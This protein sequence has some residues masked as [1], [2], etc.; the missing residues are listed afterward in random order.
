MLL[1]FAVIKSSHIAFRI[2][3]KEMHAVLLG[4]PEQRKIFIDLWKSYLRSQKFHLDME[5]MDL[6]PL[7]DHIGDGIFTK[8][9]IQNDHKKAIE[10][11]TVVENELAADPINW[12]RV[13]TAWSNWKYDHLEHLIKEEK[14][15][16]PLSIRIA[17]GHKARCLVI[18][19]KLITPADNRDS[20]EFIQFLAWC[21]RLLSFY[22]T[23]SHLPSVAT[24]IFVRGLHCCSDRAQWSRFVP[25]LKNACDQSIWAELVSKYNI[26]V[27]EEDLHSNSSLSP[28]LPVSSTVSPPTTTAV[29][30]KSSSTSDTI[31]GSFFHF[32][33]VEFFNSFCTDM[34]YFF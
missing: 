3:I 11:E 23:E 4:P 28:K 22:T 15:W 21:V 10:L 18:H 12:E 17:S 30:Q 27:A 31:Q 32:I 1:A 25:A 34:L 24:N 14:L 7:L 19:D 33:F 2:A 26:E 5:E 8:S 9:G 6:L 13:S 29:L 16:M 20:L